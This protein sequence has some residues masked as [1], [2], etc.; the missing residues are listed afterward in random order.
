MKVTRYPG[1]GDGIRTVHPIAT[2][3]RLETSLHGV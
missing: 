3:R 1:S 2:P